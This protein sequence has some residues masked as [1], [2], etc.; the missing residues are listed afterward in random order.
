[1]APPLM[2]RWAPG[3]ASAEGGA[4]L[5]SVTDFRPDRLRDAPRIA[6]TGLRLRL[7]WYAMRGAVGLRLWSLPLARRSGSISVWESEDDLRAFIRL[8]VHTE[9]MRRYRARGTL[10]STTWTADRF[11]PGEVL[12]G[13]RAWIAEQAP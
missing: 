9:I 4:V 1:M 2:T 3:P 8:P 5:V 13:A 6:A 7:G 12:R 10:R 11:D